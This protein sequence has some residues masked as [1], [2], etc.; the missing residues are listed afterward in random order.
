MAHGAAHDAAKHIAPAL[1]RGRDAIGD[2]EAGRA[3]VI[4]DDAEGGGLLALRLH[5]VELFAGRDEIDEQVGLED[6][7]DALHDGRDALETHAGVD[8]RLG[9][10]DARAA[11]V[12]LLIL[13]EDEVPEFKEPVAVLFGG[14]RRPA[15]DVVAAIDEDFRAGAAGAGVAHHPE[16]IVRRN[17]DDPRIRQAGDLLPEAVRLIVI[18]VDCDEEFVLGQVEV[19]RDQGPR[20]LDRQLL[21]IVAERKIAQHLE[22]GQ[23]ARGVADIIEVVVLAAGAD[24]FLRGR[25]ARREG[26]LGAGEDVLE[27]H[28]AGIGEQ[29]GVVTLRDERG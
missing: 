25:G 4:R 7:V 28:H 9:Q 18:V 21:E 6:G 11:V 26:L 17:A 20:M 2:E 15:P 24:A 22:E 8:G 1:V 10:G 13:H 14:P 29:Q 12:E 16:V 5:L 3:Q 23:V 19:A 27:L